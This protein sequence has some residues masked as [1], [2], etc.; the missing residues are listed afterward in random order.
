MADMTVPAIAQ[1]DATGPT[2]DEDI[3]T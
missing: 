3:K 1:L 2:F